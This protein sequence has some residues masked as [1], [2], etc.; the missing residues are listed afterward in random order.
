MA[1]GDEALKSAAKIDLLHVPYQGTAP[2]MQAVLSN[3]VMAAILP[4]PVADQF[5]KSGAVRVLAITAR[6]RMAGYPDIPTM[7]ELGIPID[8]GPWFG[9]LAPASLPPEVLARLH[10][11]IDSTMADPQVAEAM[12]KLTVVAERMDQPAYQAFY[13]S[14]FERWGRY[15]K[16]ANITLEQ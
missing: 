6:E 11:A 10:D 1:R 12:R 3:Q 9:F 8:M 2:E 13:N 5:I 15:I 7:K 14:E 16:T 4:V